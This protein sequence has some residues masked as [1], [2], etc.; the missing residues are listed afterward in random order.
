MTDNQKLD[1][2]LFNTYLINII[3][4]LLLKNDP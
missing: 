2:N 4:T 1:D 3:D